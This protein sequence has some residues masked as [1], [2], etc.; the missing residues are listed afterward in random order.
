MYPEN[1]HSAGKSSS[2]PGKV[3][4]SLQMNL[5]LHLRVRAWKGDRGRRETVKFV[6]HI[7]FSI[8]VANK[9]TN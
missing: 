1:W 5:K 7:E 2:T 8:K 6:S 9:S 4:A 3:G